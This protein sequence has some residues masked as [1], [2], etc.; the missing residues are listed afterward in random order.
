M[1]A[2]PEQAGP[3]VTWVPRPPRPDEPACWSWPLPPVL[4]ADECIAQMTTIQPGMHCDD[5]LTPDAASMVLRGAGG[6]VG[7]RMIEFH[8]DRCAI[9][10][11]R[12]P[13]L[14]DDH[15]HETG[16]TR[17]DLCRSCNVREGRSDFAIFGL[18]RWVHPA[19][20]LDVHVMYDG[21]DWGNGWSWITHP[22]EAAKRTARPPTPWPKWD[23]AA[24]LE[25]A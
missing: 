25:A 17:G 12:S 5:V 11:L 3:A 15:C 14:V 22:R 7:Y 2:T 1:E 10:G 9:C 18:Y 4:T 6:P 24:L 21:M 19:A 20:I 13:R 23:L 16:Q 8:R